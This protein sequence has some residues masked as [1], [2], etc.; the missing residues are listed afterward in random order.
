MLSSTFIILFN[1]YNNTM[2]NIIV[3]SLFLQM[4]NLVKEES[5]KFAWGHSVKS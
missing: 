2:K 5:K 4:E 3:L 1:P